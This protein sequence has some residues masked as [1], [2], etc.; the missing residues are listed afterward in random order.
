[1]SKD[2][3]P[4]TDANEQENQGRFSRTFRKPIGALK[5]EFRK[6]AEQKAERIDEKIRRLENQ[7]AKAVSQT[8]F[9][10]GQVVQKGKQVKDVAVKTTGN[11]KAFGKGIKNLR[12]KQS[13]KGL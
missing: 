11:V 5:P 3:S 1:M 4:E 9:V 13:F 12:F 6:D 8:R 7:K 10:K 2:D